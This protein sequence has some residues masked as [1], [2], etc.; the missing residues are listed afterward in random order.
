MFGPGVVGTVFVFGTGF[1][2]YR[3]LFGCQGFVGPG[4]CWHR[5][6]LVPFSLLF[7]PGFFGTGFVWGVLFW[8]PARTLSCEPPFF[9]HVPFVPALLNQGGF[10]F[11]EMK[12]I[13]LFVAMIPEVTQ[14]EDVP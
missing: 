3:L 9:A 4:I 10:W 1:R 6:L 2:W 7:G 5:L 8:Y 12:R 11:K 13:S 14:S